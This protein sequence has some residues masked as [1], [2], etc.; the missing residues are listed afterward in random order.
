MGLN[1]LDVDHF[2]VSAIIIVVMQVIFF[3]IAATLQMDK[4]TDFAGGVNFMIVALL[5]FFLG[6]AD[7]STKVRRNQKHFIIIVLFILS[8][9]LGWRSQ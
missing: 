1:L 4:I 6:Q 5:T 8:C 7:R 2:G 9:L 3:S